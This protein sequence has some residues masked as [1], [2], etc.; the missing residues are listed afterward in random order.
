MDAR[1]IL[2]QARDQLTVRRVFGEPIDRDG[3]TVVPVAVVRG[4]GGGGEQGGESAR[5]GGGWGGEARPAG[6]FI[7]RGDRV[8]WQPAVDVNRVILG[9]QVV[10]VVALLVLRSILRMRRR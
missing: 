5:W 1:Q 10:F 2:E 6:V 9:G 4:G 7:I 8:R 3:A